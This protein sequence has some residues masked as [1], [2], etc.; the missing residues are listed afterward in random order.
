MPKRSGLFSSLM[1]LIF[2]LSAFT[3]AMRSPGVAQLRSVD[4]VLLLVSGVLFGLSLGFFVVWLR[5]GTFPA[6]D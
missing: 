4:L 5:R 1:A 6:R 3:T 2:A